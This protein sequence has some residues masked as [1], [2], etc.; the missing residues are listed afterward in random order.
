MR[1]QLPSN[2]HELLTQIREGN[3]CAF[4]KIYDIYF[5]PLYCHAYNRLRDKDDAKDVVQEL[6][7][8]LWLKRDTLEP[9]TNLSNYLY[10]S[11]RNRILNL[12]AHKQVESRYRLLLPTLVSVEACITDHRLRERQL[13]E[14][15]EKETQALP[16]KMRRVFEMSRKDNM[17]Y[18]EIGDQLEISE[19]SVRSHVKNAL[20]ILRAKLAVII[21]VICIIYK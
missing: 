6:F 8:V 11:V 21:Y 20:K 16:P 13:A 5:T 15:I 17:T 19:Q 12:I 7:T 18:K 10:T 1:S 9:N 3:R 4:S 2:E 14:I